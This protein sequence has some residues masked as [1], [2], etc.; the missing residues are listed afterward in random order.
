MH[1]TLRK[2]SVAEWAGDLPLG[3]RYASLRNEAYVMVPE[4][5]RPAKHRGCPIYE[6]PPNDAG[7]NAA[8][9]KVPGS[10]A[11]A[12]TGTVSTTEPEPPRALRLAGKTGPGPSSSTKHR[13]SQ[14]REGQNLFTTALSR[15]DHPL[16]E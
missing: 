14:G 12:G 15:S 2:A 3:G 8:G 10:F 9:H 4:E 13:L 16:I 6:Y 11:A 7:W 1:C 5:R